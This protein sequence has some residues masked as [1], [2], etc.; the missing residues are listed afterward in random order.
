VASRVPSHNLRVSW[1]RV[2]GFL[3][4]LKA[5][6]PRFLDVIAE[7]GKPSVVVSDD[8]EGFQGPTVRADNRAGIMQAVA[9]L[10][11]HG[12]RRIA[13]AGY[14]AQGD[15]RERLA[16]YR[17][18]LTASNID[19][20]DSLVF[21]APNN[22]ESGGEVAAR[23]MLDAGMPSTAV[24]AGTDFN[25]IGIM[26]V[27]SEAGL[28]LPGDQAV[29]GFDDVAAGSSMRP[30]LSTVHQGVLE[31]GRTALDLLLQMLGGGAVR[32]G[33]H[34]VPTAF[35]PRESC[36]CSH[37]A[38][39]DGPVDGDAPETETPEE[40]FR[41]RLERFLSGR[42]SLS[43]AQR[44]ALDGAAELTLR[45]ADHRRAAGRPATAELREASR[46]L[47]AVSPYW[48]TITSWRSVYRNT[49]TRSPAAL[50]ATGRRRSLTTSCG[51][52]WSSCRARSR[53]S[54]ATHAPRSSCRGTPSTT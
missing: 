5:V 9:H 3:I 8:M 10:V 49:G 20:D 42:D 32:P 47:L 12:H 39:V 41:R 14:Q 50:R 31:M 43:V 18:A 4:V 26:K 52:W 30:S 51:R 19:P 40:H 53:N 33:R 28:S 24:V 36:G 46:A 27:L 23:S 34:L 48:T 22:L 38:A 45:L 35:V 15:I 2:D 1:D 21:A 13:F 17:E 11:E 44:Q 25:A 29:I 6:E 7:A 16:A 54:R 37:A